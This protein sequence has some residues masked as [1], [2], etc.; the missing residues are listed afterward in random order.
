LI[1][2]AELDFLFSVVVNNDDFVPGTE[3]L[4][5]SYNQPSVTA[6]G[7]VVF[8]ARSQGGGGQPATGIFFGDVEGSAIE[9]LTVRGATVPAPNNTGATFNEFPS[10]PRTDRDSFTVAFRGQSEP[11][12]SY[13]ETRS[14]TSG[15]YSNPSGPLITGAS[16]LGVPELPQFSYFSVP[17]AE[18]GTRFD[19]FPGAPSPTN[20]SIAFKGNWTA[21]VEEETGETEGQTGVYFRDLVADGGTSPVRLIADSNTLIPGTTEIEFGSTAPPSAADDKV[22]FLGVDNEDDPNYGGIYLSGLNGDPTDLKTLVSLGGLADLVDHEGGLTGIEEVL[23]F[24]GR[25]V[26]W[27][28][29]WG[30]EADSRYQLISCP[31][32]GNQDRLAYCHQLSIDGEQGGIGQ[33]TDDLYYFLREIP[34]YQGIFITDTLTMETRLIAS[35]GEDYD[36]FLF[37]NFSGRSPEVGEGGGHGGEAD[38]LAPD[39]DEEEGDLELARWRESVFM[40]LDGPDLAFKALELTPFNLNTIG[41]GDQFDGDVFIESKQ[42][43][44]YQDLLAETAALPVIESGDDGGIL[45]ARAQG[46]P[47]VGLGL[48]RDGLRSGNLVFSASMAAEAETEE[49]EDID[50]W[51]GI[52]SAKVG[53]GG[54]GELPRLVATEGGVAVVGPEGEGL[55]VELSVV[56]AMAAWQNSLSALLNSSS[57]RSPEA[58]GALGSTPI[59]GEVGL[60][61]GLRTVFLESGEELSFVQSTGERPPVLNPALQVEGTDPSIRLGLDDGGGGQDADYND[62][63]LNIRSIDFEPNPD[64]QISLPQVDATAG[65]LDLTQFGGIDLALSV[66]TY[67]ELSNT[68]R[69]VEVEVDPMTGLKTVGG[70]AEGSTGFLDAVTAH[71]ESFSYTLGGE[72]NSG[73]TTWQDIDA[74]LYAPVLITGIG[75]V[76]TFGA[77]GG[78]DG[79]AHLKVLG[80]N[81]FSFE[82]LLA[83]QGPDW[84]YND[85]ILSAQVV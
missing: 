70:I 5:N 20:S 14:G 55:W 39:A 43:I 80:Q 52:Y 32:E 68:L 7:E 44:Y 65:L 40:A 67:S 51:A 50:T 66:S 23:S 78:S 57:S 33:G 4:F 17:G 13:E 54:N 11:V 15:V 12:Y 81:L 69:F 76:L 21:V 16:Q 61:G 27:W 18:P 49:G 28:G 73:S 6:D 41:L 72:G 74:G 42:G 60:L 64:H 85:F 56:G 82:D 62:L 79:F 8:R 59:A 71:L 35:T 45:D 34:E 10:F 30:D 47:V 24:D 25:T 83:G 9:A 36:S 22:V 38:M 53:S 77:S 31:E 1:I 2:M 26:A 46:L 19:Q 29:A 37:F 48:E 84:D 63:V 3:R 75:D 58:V